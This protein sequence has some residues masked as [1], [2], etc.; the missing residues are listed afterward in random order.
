MNKLHA[1][2]GNIK[3]EFKETLKKFPV[4]SFLIIAASIWFSQTIVAGVNL[5]A[6]D[7]PKTVF[8]FILL[9][10]VGSFLVESE[11]IRNPFLRWAL[12]V[13]AGAAAFY[14]SELPA[15]IRLMAP[16]SQSVSHYRVERIQVSYGLILFSLGLFNTFR[17]TG[18]KFGE[19]T[20]KSLQNL[21]QAAIVTLVFVIGT[22]LVTYTFNYLILSDAHNNLVPRAVFLVAGIGAGLG[23]LFALSNAEREVAAFT[24]SIVRWVLLPLLTI[25][26]VI[27]YAYMIKILF[28]S[29][30]PSNQVYGILAGL[31]LIGLPIWTVMTFF[32]KKSM[33]VKI[34]TALPLFFLPILGL[35]AYVIWLRISSFGLTPTR[36]LGVMLVIFELIAV[37]IYI[38][39]REKLS[40]IL[41][42]FSVFVLISGILPKINMDDFSLADQYRQITRFDA[43]V[44]PELPAEERWRMMSAY[45]YL[46]KNE[47]GK[48]LLGNLA[49]KDLEFLKG[50]R[51]ETFINEEDNYL[52]VSSPL[53]NLPLTG[54]KQASLVNGYSPEG[55]IDYAKFKLTDQD[56]EQT[57]EID[58]TGLEEFLRT[59]RLQNYQMVDKPLF[60][61]LP[62]GSR[63]YISHLSA[64]TKDG[65][66]YDRVSF[67]GLLLIP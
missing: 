58:L 41:P 23:I 59:L 49:P 5:G 31:F 50:Y 57:K 56:G 43:A 45:D 33:P 39:Q 20:L 67:M 24:A 66:Q 52:S 61:D 47:K 29:E 16:D 15:V 65:V 10:G 12:L 11:E 53:A 8:I 35:Q 51:K 25:A 3:T 19:Y 40:W 46:N 55:K 64:D 21:A 26:F 7:F 62:D 36:Y 44:F 6:P 38:W 27:V 17:R 4:T 54:Y 34:G 22:A 28:I 37:L 48:A 1:L 32:P 30:I 14:L 2:T 42:V 60:W 63:L 13:I 18:R 9:W